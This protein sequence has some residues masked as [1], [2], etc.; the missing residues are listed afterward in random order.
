MLTQFFTQTRSYRFIVWRICCFVQ[1]PTYWSMHLRFLPI[2][3]IIEFIHKLY[4][5]PQLLCETV[6]VGFCNSWIFSPYSAS[7][8]WRLEGKVCRSIQLAIDYTGTA[9]DAGLVESVQRAGGSAR[10]FSVSAP[11]FRTRGRKARPLRSL[12]A[13]RCSVLAADA[14]DTPLADGWRLREISW[15]AKNS[16]YS[17]VC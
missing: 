4:S 8:L 15:S 14:D 1:L 13:L 11:F 2:K 17:Y 12:P 7:Q 9:S 6:F 3:S 16:W 5:P 10:F